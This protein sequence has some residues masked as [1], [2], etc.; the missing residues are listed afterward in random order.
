MR[1]GIAEMTTRTINSHSKISNS[2]TWRYLVSWKLLRKLTSSLT[3]SIIRE[4]KSSKSVC[5]ASKWGW[6]LG[7]IKV[8][9]LKVQLDPSTRSMLRIFH[10]MSIWPLGLRRPPSNMGFICL[11]QIISM[12]C[13]L[14]KSSWCAEKLTESLWREALCQSHFIQWTLTQISSRRRKTHCMVSVIKTA[15]RY[16]IRK[17]KCSW[18]KSL[19]ESRPP[20]TCLQMIKTSNPSDTTMIDTSP[21]NS[22]RPT[23]VT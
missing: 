8:G 7:F 16:V 4:T 18:K 5:Q 20:I 15:R 21:R 9:P 22:R 3:F 13:S 19:R 1:M 11:F 17:R 2:L 10:Q 12:L 6:A 14:K 23:S